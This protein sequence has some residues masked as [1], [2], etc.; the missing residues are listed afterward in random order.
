V[1]VYKGRAPVFLTDYFS[2][3][4]GNNTAVVFIVV[5]GNRDYDDALLEL[6]IFLKEMVLLVLP[7][8]HLLENIQILKNWGR[9]ELL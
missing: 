7:E 5:Y 8:V 2:R 3:V 4:K 1:P 6:D 9:S